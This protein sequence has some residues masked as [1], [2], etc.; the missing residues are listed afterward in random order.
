M[1]LLGGSRGGVQLKSTR[2]L[3]S[4]AEPEKALHLAQEQVPLL[5]C[6]LY[7]ELQVPS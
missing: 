3:R 6:V 1:E 5:S 7:M 2:S 4:C